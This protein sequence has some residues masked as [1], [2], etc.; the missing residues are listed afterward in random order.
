MLQDAISIGIK[1]NWRENL[2]LFEIRIRNGVKIENSDGIN[3]VAFYL[4]QKDIKTMYN[5]L[6]VHLGFIDE[7]VE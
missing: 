2:D 7:Y 1:A 5:K 4:S 3:H 6:N